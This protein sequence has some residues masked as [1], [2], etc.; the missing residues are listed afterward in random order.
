MKMCSSCH[1]SAKCEFCQGE[2]F[3]KGPHIDGNITMHEMGRCSV[4][5]GTGKCPSCSP[6][7]AILVV[8]KAVLAS[9]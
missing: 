5:F 3:N 7:A 8:R 4:C 2:G 9:A 1:G 6:D